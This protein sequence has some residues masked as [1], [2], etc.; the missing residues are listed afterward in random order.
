MKN[1]A[2]LIAGKTNPTSGTK[3]AGK[4]VAVIFNL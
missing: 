2:I 3:I 4:N 1:N